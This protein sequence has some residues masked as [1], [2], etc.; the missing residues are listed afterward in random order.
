[1]KIRGWTA[2]EILIGLT[3]SGGMASWIT[4]EVVSINNGTA[5]PLPKDPIEYVI[6]KDVGGQIHQDKGYRIEVE[7]SV[8]K[9][10]KRNN[11]PAVFI[12]MDCWTSEETTT[13][14]ETTNDV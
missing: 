13:Y 4:S 14:Q 6:C 7:G 5:D 9:V 11:P 3:V 8:V 1:M 2:V 10:Y 12:N